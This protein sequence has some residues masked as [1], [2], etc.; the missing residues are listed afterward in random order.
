MLEMRMCSFN[1]N[2]IA[3][4][5]M[6][7]VISCGTEKDYS[8]VTLLFCITLDSLLHYFLIGERE[9][10]RERENIYLFLFSPLL[11][12]QCYPSIS[13]YVSSNVHSTLCKLTHSF[14]T[15]TFWGRYSNYTHYADEEPEAERSYWSW[16]TRTVSGRAGMLTQE[17]WLLRL[18]I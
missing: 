2:G 13:Y 12:K 17:V 11:W 4:T 1:S 15:I 7:G 8:P 18:C 3:K 5:Q 16:I 6:Q 10:E 14:L 9:R